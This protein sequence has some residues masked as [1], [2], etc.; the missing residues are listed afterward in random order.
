MLRSRSWKNLKGQKILEARTCSR[1]FYLQLRNPGSNYCEPCPRLFICKFFKAVCKLV[2]LSCMAFL[3]VLFMSR[4]LRYLL[5]MCS[6]WLKPCSAIYFVGNS[7]SIKSL[8]YPQ[9][10]GKRSLH[11]I[12]K[13]WP[14]VLIKYG[15]GFI[16]ALEFDEKFLEVESQSLMLVNWQKGNLSSHFLRNPTFGVISTTEW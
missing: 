15:H 7:S 5:R 14:S 9:T 10:S 1:T 6:T 13:V 3:Q 16:V 8:T 12:Q 4:R 2:S 11:L